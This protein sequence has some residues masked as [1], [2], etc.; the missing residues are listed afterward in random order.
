MV[1]KNL[2]IQLPVLMVLVLFCCASIVLLRDSSIALVKIDQGSEFEQRVAVTLPVALTPTP[3]VPFFSTPTQE[4]LVVKV[5]KEQERNFYQTRGL[6]FDKDQITLEFR[7]PDQTISVAF[8]P[9]SGEGQ[10]CEVW[11]MDTACTFANEKAVFVYFH[12][13]LYRG[14]FELAEPLR[15]YIEGYRIYKSN[16]VYH[17]EASK[18]LAEITQILDSIKGSEVVVDGEVSYT[19]VEVIRIS[20]IMVDTSLSDVDQIYRTIVEEVPEA[21]RTEPVI[22]PYFCGWM[23]KGEEGSADSTELIWSRYI[24]VLL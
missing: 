22:L 4:S 14:K 20:P 3:F 17:Y 6:A 18:T 23:V 19:L 8:Q 2:K 10:K 9:A 16:G 5:E 11:E 15:R 13:G 12:T 21:E 24:F 1:V 7:F